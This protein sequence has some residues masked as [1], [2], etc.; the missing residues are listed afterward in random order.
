MVSLALTLWL[1][2]DSTKQLTQFQARRFESYRLAEELRQSSDDL[3]RMARTYT[4]TGDKRFKEYFRTIMAIRDGKE[5]R[6]ENYQNI[7]W[8]FI[9]SHHEYRLGNGSKTPII[10]QMVKLQFSEHE[11]SALAEAKLLSDDLINMEIQ[12]FNAMEGLFI[13]E[14]GQYKDTGKP[15]QEFARQILH[16]PEYHQAKAKIMEHV[17]KFFLLLESRTFRD[18][19]QN[20]SEQKKLFIIVISLSILLTI[21]S[22]LGYYNFS[23]GIIIPLND[24][25]SWIKRMRN[26][27]YDFQDN[28]HRNDEIGVLARTFVEMAQK[29]SSNIDELV[30]VSHTDPLTKINNRIAIDEALNKEKY[31]FDRYHTECSLILIDIDHFKDVNDQFGHIIGDKVL[32]EVA[33]ILRDGIRESD[34]VGRWGGEEFLIICPNTG[35]EKSRILAETLR[36][37]ISDFV[38]SGVGHK[39]ASFGVFALRKVIDLSEILTE[40]DRRLYM[41]KQQGRNIVC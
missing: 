39:T 5:P 29:V 25:L 11:L 16:S 3:T 15:D 14:D 40:V 22:V 20:E 9:T 33:I 28:L 41:A 38:F 18:V 13:G 35:L 2:L 32:I 26:G 10:E 6:P 7:F 21:V 37:K 36:K 12:A 1:M 30:H 23:H 4:V 8:D 17:N 34:T 31:K 19:Q 27:K 24:I